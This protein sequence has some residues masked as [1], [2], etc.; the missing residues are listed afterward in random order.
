M[1]GSRAEVV[2]WTGGNSCLISVRVH[3]MMGT[4]PLMAMAADAVT[5]TVG[6]PTGD[7]DGDS[8]AAVT[9]AMAAACSTTV[10]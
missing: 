9:T 4:I 5:V 2:S 6:L 8:G 10:V 3:V 7:G 1:G